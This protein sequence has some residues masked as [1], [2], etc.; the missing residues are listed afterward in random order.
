MTWRTVIYCHFQQ[1]RSP[2]LFIPYMCQRFQLRSVSLLSL[3]SK[4][5]MGQ[6]K[7]A[8]A[9]LES[10]DYVELSSQT[11]AWILEQNL[12][13]CKRTLCCSNVGQIE[14]PSP[15]I[16]LKQISNEQTLCWGT[17]AAYEV[18]GHNTHAVGMRAVT[19]HG[20]QSCLP[21][22]RTQHAC[23][24]HEGC[25]WVWLSEWRAVVQNGLAHC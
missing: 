11:S 1:D 21:S 20:Y 13:H 9:V 16:V 7:E 19:E 25:D 6:T 14:S 24:G 18:S 5:T 2:K 4:S 3:K 22:F 17:C 15:G 10:P 23:C 12:V 8:A